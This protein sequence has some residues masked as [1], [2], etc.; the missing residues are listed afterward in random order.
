M[1]IKLHLV[2]L[3]AQEYDPIVIDLY[4]AEHPE[5]RLLT[6]DQLSFERHRQA[7]PR[8]SSVPTIVAPSVGLGTQ[9]AGGRL[10]LAVP[11]SQLPNLQPNAGPSVDAVTAPL[12]GQQ[13]GG[14]LPLAVPESQLPNLQ[15]NAGPSVDAVTAPLAGLGIL[16]VGGPIPPAVPDLRL[17]D[18]L[19]N[20]GQRILTHS[21][22][23]STIRS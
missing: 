23:K 14:R 10:P 21:V 17:P 16:T 11:E 12:A 2:S 5:I 20:A 19:P 4:I 6:R 18:H 7:T 9:Q 15:P 3:R 22:L 8:Y 13:A 1:T